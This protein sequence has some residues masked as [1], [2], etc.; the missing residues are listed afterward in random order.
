MEYRRLGKT[1][2]QA[3]RLGLGSLRLPK[4]SFG[5]TEYIDFDRSVE[6]LHSAFEQG[7]N[8]VD[9]ALTYGNSQSE[10]AVG[11]AL[12]AWPAADEVI[13]VTKANPFQIEKSGDL[14]RMLEHQLERLERQWIHFYLFHGIGWENFHETERKAGWMGDMLT[15]REEGLVRHVGF[16]FHDTPARMKDLVDLGWAELVTCQYNYLDRRNHEAMAYAAGRGVAVVVMGPVGGGRLS[17]LPRGVAGRLNVRERDAAELALRYVASVPSVDVVLSG[18]SDVEM[19]RYN[20][21]A[22]GKG[23]LSPEEA[24]VLRTLMDELAGLSDLPCSGCEYCMPCPSKVNIARCFELFNY[25][26]VYGLE[27]YAGAEYARLMREGKDAGRCTEC[28]ACVE[29]CPQRIPI[30]EELRRV[31]QVMN[32]VVPKN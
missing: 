32:E 2:L 18:M 25:Q 8:Y 23:P 11:R 15:A 5:G 21:S 26:T 6:V 22:M 24:G 14:R 31:V 1:G 7:I 16:S 20:V 3:S 30:P 9:M 12:R 17:V 13:L 27:E 29:K 19:V 10:L 28:L 4:T